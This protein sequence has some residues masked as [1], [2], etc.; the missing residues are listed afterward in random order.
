MPGQKISG[1]RLFPTKSISTFLGGV[2]CFI[3][4]HLDRFRRP[5]AMDFRE[6]V[7]SSSI[8]PPRRP[9]GRKK[10]SSRSVRQTLRRHRASAQARLTDDR[11]RPPAAQLVGVA[12]DTYAVTEFSAHRE[13]STSAGRMGVRSSGRI[14]ISNVPWYSNILSSNHMGVPL[15]H[16]GVLRWNPRDDPLMTRGAVTKFQNDLPGSQ[17]GWLQPP[18]PRLLATS[19]GTQSSKAS[20]SVW[21]RPARKLPGAVPRDRWRQ[22]KP[23]AAHL[24]PAWSPH[25]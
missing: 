21:S 4:L 3:L 16:C 23:T 14:T 17:N 15:A 25:P 22:P 8:V 13:R 1:P 18:N 9:D 5:S 6:S 7:G 12:P 2:S 19:F 10:A 20:R 11:L 24:G